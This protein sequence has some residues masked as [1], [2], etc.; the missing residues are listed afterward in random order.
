VPHREHTSKMLK[1]G[2]HSQGISH[3]YLHTPHSSANGMSYNCLFLASQSWSSFTDPPG[4]M[5]G[6]V[7]AG[8]NLLQ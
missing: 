5:E 2:T 4:G 7:G 8:D 3:L 6:W 1:Y